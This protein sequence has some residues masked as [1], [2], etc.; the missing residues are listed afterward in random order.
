MINR[1]PICMSELDP[2]PQ[3]DPEI[4]PEPEFSPIARFERFGIAGKQVVVPHEIGGVACRLAELAR[5]IR[6][7]GGRDDD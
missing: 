1:C 3:T 4:A 6:S 7:V 2:L 5:T